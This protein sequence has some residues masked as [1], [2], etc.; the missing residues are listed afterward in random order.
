M[1]SSAIES[2]VSDGSLSAAN[3]PVNDE[4]VK[5]ADLPL[6]AALQQTL[7]K[8]EYT[9]PTPI[10]AA[11]IP[12]I[13]A[14]RDV[15]GQ[16]QT[17]T[18]KTAA[19]ALPLLDR[20]DVTSLATQVLVLAPT[21]ELA[22]QVAESFERYAMNLPKFRV[23]AIYGG[24]AY[25]IQLQ[26][27]RRGVQVV[28]GTPGR[29]MDHLRRGTLKLD[30]IRC[31]VLDEA[32]EML[33]M[34]FADD[35]EWILT[36]APS[37]RQIA[38][39][40]ATLPPPIRRI[41][42]QHLHEPAEVTIAAQSAT[43]STVRQRYV[44]VPQ[45]QKTAALLRLVEAE[46][47]DAAIVF[48]KLKSTTEP[49]AEALTSA[50][51]RAAALSGDLAQKQR[52]RIIEQ[53]KAGQIDVVVA[54]D[55][56]ARGLDVP[57]I[58]H[59]FNF[60]LPLDDE[61]YVHRIGRTGRAGRS[62]EA[63]LFVHP[64]EL[65]LLKRLQQVTRRQME[66]MRVP[67]NAQ[68]NARRLANFQQRITEVLAETE[69][70]EFEAMIEQF[71]AESPETPPAKVAAA[72]A[73][74]LHEVQP[75][76]VSGAD[77]FSGA[78]FSRGRDHDGPSPRREGRGGSGM[79]GKEQYRLEVGRVH[80]VKPGNIMGAIA[81]EAGLGRDAIGRIEIFDN[82]STVELPAGM[83]SGIF[84]RLKRAMVAGQ[85]LNLSR[86][87]AGRRHSPR[88]ADVAAPS[89]APAAV[90]EEER[91]IKKLL[92]LNRSKAANPS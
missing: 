73:L 26:Q 7:A 72:I 15:I 66:E 18:G 68:L 62:G 20:V 38:L 25:E 4:A 65:R 9:T 77:E 56:A 28:V 49:L 52:E 59:V 8:L 54:T 60:D 27:L 29:V 40:S 75:L 51:Y 10:Q 22:I 21:R 42:Q 55:V 12:W 82:F 14:G 61:A 16:A 88:S 92:R 6:S 17:G 67:D 3:E 2:N 45:H 86:V 11:A 13:A 50:G 89:T 80:Q 78:S 58:S 41:A 32:D 5:F 83:P 39:F 34:G 70:P 91:P 36:Q 43:A 53:L 69:L 47:I 84:Q 64:R 37:P 81:N 87:E 48:V 85:R 30:A 31:V 46:G 76:V 24:Q 71:L 63:I 57:R 74:M 44:V 19:F 23:A 79:A 33:K 1:L 35:V 90:E